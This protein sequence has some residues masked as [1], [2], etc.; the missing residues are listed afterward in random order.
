MSQTTI[1]THFVSRKRL[2][3][4][5]DRL[6]GPRRRGEFITAAVDEKLKREQL[7]RATQ[8]AMALPPVRDIA[9]WDTPDAASQ[10]VHDLRQESDRARSV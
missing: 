9:A 8:N 3:D 7:L 4:E 10:W 2:I 1:R 6:V 5:V